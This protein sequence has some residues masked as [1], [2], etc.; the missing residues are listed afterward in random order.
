MILGKERSED[1]P[2]PITVQ[3]GP[4]RRTYETEDEFVA[5]MLSLESKICRGIHVKFG[6][7]QKRALKID[8]SQGYFPIIYAN[9]T[10][11]YDGRPLAK[12]VK[13]VLDVSN[14]VLP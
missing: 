14:S 5:Q 1:S 2:V 7:E 6:R 13:K 4:F 10:S 12:T 8:I 11:H 9:H 3:V